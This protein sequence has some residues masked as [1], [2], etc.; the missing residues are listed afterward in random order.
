[1]IDTFWKTC[2]MRPMTG[3]LALSGA[4]LAATDAFAEA[5]TSVPNSPIPVQRPSTPEALHVAPVTHRPGAK[6]CLAEAIYFES[7]GTS[8]RAA[9]AV[10]HVILN[11][12][13]RE[14]FPE[15]VCGVVTEG[16]QFSYRCDGKPDTLA[17]AAERDRAYRAAE[18]VLEGR[19]FDPTNG[20]LFF[21]AEAVRPGWFKT[22][23]HLVEIGGNI[24][25]R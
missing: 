22:L 9:H 12:R 19:T 7:L 4:L 25:Y 17:D 23:D 10:A 13:E 5:A 3:A 20:A 14:E 18:A 8:D 11:R 16:C 2:V 24:F 1:M 21:H 15:T 6:A